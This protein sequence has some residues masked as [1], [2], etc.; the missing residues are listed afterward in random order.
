MKTSLGLPT[1]DLPFD[2]DTENLYYFLVK[3]DEENF[4][5]FYNTRKFLETASDKD[6]FSGTYTFR[7]SS[8][9]LIMY[10]SYNVYTGTWVKASKGKQ[11]YSTSNLSSILVSSDD[12]VNNA[13]GET[14]VSKTTYKEPSAYRGE[15]FILS[16]SYNRDWIKGYLD[17]NQDPVVRN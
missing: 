9:N 15:N 6:G 8:Y 1:E 4:Y 3:E 13:T 7:D 5:F 10:Y 16:A 14:I 11:G 17:L 2:F 12:I